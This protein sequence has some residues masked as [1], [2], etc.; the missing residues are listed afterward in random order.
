[1]KKYFVYLFLLLPVLV[2]LTPQ[3]SSARELSGRVTMVKGR[4]SLYKGEDKSP[5][6]VKDSLKNSRK[7]SRI[8]VRQ[9]LK[10]GDIISIPAESRLNITF[11]SEKMR[12]DGP[13][14]FKIEEVSTSRKATRFLYFFKRR[15]TTNVSRFKLFYGRVLAKVKKLRRHDVHELETPTAVM[16]VYGT[17]YLTRATSEGKGDISVLSGEVRMSFNQQP[18]RTMAIFA[19]NQVRLVTKPDEQV[20]IKPIPPALQKKLVKAVAEIKDAPPPPSPE[21]IE[22]EKAGETEGE[23]ETESPE[24]ETQPAEGEGDTEPADDAEDLGSFDEGKV[25]EDDEFTTE[26]S[27]DQSLLDTSPTPTTETAIPDSGGTTSPLELLDSGSPSQDSFFQAIDDFNTFIGH[28]GSG[29]GTDESQTPAGA[30]ENK[31]VDVKVKID[32]TGLGD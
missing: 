18:E 32:W 29:H 14:L 31:Q 5:Q 20:E 17:S 13:T 10:A 1:M 27:T 26:E 12:L 4:A 2:V 8:K 11:P 24:D 7:W 23:E 22:E 3:L 16:G 25:L 6:T 30:L 9:Q 21:E 15:R 28:E 19:G